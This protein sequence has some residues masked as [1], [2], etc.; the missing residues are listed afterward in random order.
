M[1]LGDVPGDLGLETGGSGTTPAM[2]VGGVRPFRKN[3]PLMS[4]VILALGLRDSP[5]PRRQVVGC[6]PQSV[7]RLLPKVCSLTQ[8]RR[9]LELGGKP[10][11]GRGQWLPR[12]PCEA[13]VV[14]AQHPAQHPAPGAPWAKFWRLPSAS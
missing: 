3:L 6:K 12:A 14:L 10:R 9:D 13:A 8:K 5:A 1:G 4:S 2:V 7:P 11:P